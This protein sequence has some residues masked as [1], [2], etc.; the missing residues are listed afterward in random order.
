MDINNLENDAL[1]YD[2]S[3]AANPLI[4]KIITPIPYK[5]FSLHFLRERT[6]VSYR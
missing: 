6:L 2:Y 5:S 4:Q 1:Y 3:S